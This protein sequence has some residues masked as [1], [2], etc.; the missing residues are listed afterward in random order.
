MTTPAAGNSWAKLV[1]AEITTADGPASAESFCR[2]AAAYEA[3]SF[4]NVALAVLRKADSFGI[5]KNQAI[6]PAL[7]RGLRKQRQFAE[8]HTALQAGL[9]INDREAGLRRELALALA[10]LS[11]IPA[12]EME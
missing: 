3:A 10:C 4:P 1:Q 7:L 9:A 12:A 6:L 5:E 2:V 11:Q 8:L